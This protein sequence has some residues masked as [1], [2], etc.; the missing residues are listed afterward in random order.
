MKQHMRDRRGGGACVCHCYCEILISA[1]R[2]SADKLCIDYH[3]HRQLYALIEP[4]A[5]LQ[6]KRG[7]GDAQLTDGN[8][9]RPIR[10]VMP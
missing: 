1:S 6:G 10:N 5:E 9:K 3:R 8:K 7:N 2:P 4:T